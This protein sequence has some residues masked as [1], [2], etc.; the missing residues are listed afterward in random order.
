MIAATTPDVEAVSIREFVGSTAA[1]GRVAVLCGT[2]GQGLTAEA[3]A[4]ADLRLRIPMSGALD[5]LNVA[6]VAGIYSVA[7]MRHEFDDGHF[8]QVRLYYALFHLFA[9][10]QF[11]C[12]K[13]CSI[14]RSVHTL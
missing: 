8:A 6:T 13:T 3:L 4:R 10:A 5:S 2:E 14:G 1:K 7:Y 11:Q 9:A 12:G